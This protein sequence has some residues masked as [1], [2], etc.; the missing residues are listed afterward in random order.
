MSAPLLTVAEVAERLRKAERFVLDELRRKNLAGS[1]YGGAWH[2]SEADLDVYIDAH[3]NV[4]RVR[5]GGVA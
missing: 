1:K 3:R 2:V 4:S 5:G